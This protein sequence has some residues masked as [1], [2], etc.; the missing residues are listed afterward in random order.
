MAVGIIGALALLLLLPFNLTGPW[1]H[2]RSTDDSWERARA[3]VLDEAFARNFGPDVRIVPET[4]TLLERTDRGVML[5]AADTTAGGLITGLIGGGAGG[6]SATTPDSPEVTVGFGG[7]AENA[8]AHFVW[9]QR[10]PSAAS[11]YR[12][13]LLEFP[14]DEALSRYMGSLD[15]IEAS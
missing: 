3:E 14:D 11:G 7:S 5:W 4:L 15:G 13:R 8:P 1:N 12:H 10:A 9:V 2:P 6:G